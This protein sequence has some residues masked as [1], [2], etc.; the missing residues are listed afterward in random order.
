MLDT[1]SRLTVTTALA[2]GLSLLA[3]AVADPPAAAPTP[4]DDVR[5]PDPVNPVP[6]PAPVPPASAAVKLGKGQVYAVQSTGP[7]VIVQRGEGK[8]SVTLRKGAVTFPADSAPGVKPTKD[9]PGFVTLTGPYTYLVRPLATG[10]VELQVIPALNPTATDAKT[11]ATSQVPLTAA[12]IK[13]KRLDVDAG[14]GPRPPPDVDPKPPEPKPPTPPDP[15][16]KAEKLWVVVVHE[17]S[18]FSEAKN[19]VLGDA[20]FWKT[21]LD[22]GHEFRIYD[23]DS[24]EAKALKYDAEFVKTGGPTLLLID[25]DT[26]RTLKTVRLPATT[27]GVDAE[28]KAVTK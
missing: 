14:T 6:Q 24:A 16:P 15:T 17:T 18:A 1:L 28:I 22:R 21:V 27:T 11:K 7:L 12:R 5:F 8:V 10:Q 25:R 19:A 20:P 2:L 23:K 26:K 13:Y 3:S 4:A 9:D